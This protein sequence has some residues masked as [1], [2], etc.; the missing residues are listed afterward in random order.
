MPAFRNRLGTFDTRMLA[1][2]GAFEIQMTNTRVQNYAC[3]GCDVGSS[4]RAYGRPDGF[5]T[6]GDERPF[7]VGV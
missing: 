4:K 7:D 2:S 3:F 6:D 1:V 5:Y